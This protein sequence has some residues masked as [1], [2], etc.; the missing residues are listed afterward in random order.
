MVI[1]IYKEEKKNE[2]KNYNKRAGIKRFITGER[3]YTSNDISHVWHDRANCIANAYTRFIGRLFIV[4]YNGA[5]I[6]HYYSNNK[7][8][9]YRYARD[10]SDGCNNGN[11]AGNIRTVSLF[12]YKKLKI[13]T[14][15][16]IDYFNDCRKNCGRT[17]SCCISPTFRD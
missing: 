2:E 15:S 1:F 5:F 14:N 4:T 6:G 10:V 9:A 16:F 17:D 13:V 7:R 8:V 3:N 11:R 12:K